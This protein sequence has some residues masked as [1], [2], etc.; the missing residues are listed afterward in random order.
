MDIELIERDFKSVVCKEIRLMQEG[1]DRFKVFTPFIFDDGDHFSIVLKRKNNNWIISDEGHTFMHLSYSMSIDD[2][3]KGT[4]A[5]II[6]NTLENFGITESDG[7]LSIVFNENNSGNAFYN[8]I[9]GLIKITDITFL[10]RERIKS[11]FFEDFKVFVESKV[12][13]DRIEFNYH[14]MKYDPQGYYP[15]DCRINSM[16]RPIY[17]FAIHNDDKCRDVTIYLLQYE[18]WGVPFQS[19]S[20]FEDQETVN[21]KVLARFSDVCEKQFSS[22]VTNKERI[23]SYIKEKIS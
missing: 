20:I 22:L 23:E 9:Q 6:S 11:T 1:L 14:H 8:F 13:K 3:E 5:K 2:I 7:K 15:V 12:N 10:G 4:R 16:P 19:I 21:R 17:L 18:K